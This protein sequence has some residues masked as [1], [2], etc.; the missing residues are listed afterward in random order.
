MSGTLENLSLY[1]LYTRG[2]AS[3]YRSNAIFANLPNFLVPIAS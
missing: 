3:L 1:K 2:I